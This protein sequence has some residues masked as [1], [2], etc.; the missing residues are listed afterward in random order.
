MRNVAGKGGSS[1]VAYAKD[2]PYWGI[3]RFG[4]PLKIVKGLCGDVVSYSV[5]LGATLERPRFMYF[6]VAGS[7]TALIIL[8]A[9]RRYYHES[10]Q[11]WP[12]AKLIWVLAGVGME[13]L[14][15]VLIAIGI[16]ETLGLEDSLAN[17]FQAIYIA[18]TAVGIALTLIAIILLIVSRIRYGD[19]IRDQKAPGRRR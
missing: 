1:G 18:G 3:E 19:F 14:V 4:I 15:G 7:V 12:L 17:I 6:I 16:N 5:H 10:R 11:R 8:L 13:S 9:M 2:R